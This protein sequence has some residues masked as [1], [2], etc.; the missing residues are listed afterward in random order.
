MDYSLL[1]GIHDEE[2]ADEFA[3]YSFDAADENGVDSG[4]GTGEEDAEG[5]A[6]G[7]TPPDSPTVGTPPVFQGELDPILDRFAI[8]CNEGLYCFRHLQSE[9]FLII[10]HISQHIPTIS[11]AFIL[12]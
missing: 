7:L 2:R 8:R 1:V 10:E 12:V 6:G 4:D 3:N 11:L 5:L 9:L